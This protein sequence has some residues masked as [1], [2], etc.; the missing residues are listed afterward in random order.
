[1]F[2]I[3]RATFAW[4]LIATLGGVALGAEIAQRAF[5]RVVLLE[6]K[7]ETSAGV[8]IG[9]LN[10]DGF[11]DIVLA[12]GRHWPLHDRVLLNDGHGKFSA[13]NLGET[14]DRTYS[15]ALAD[16]NGDGSLD[17]VVSNDQPD[18]KLIYLN[19]GKARFRIAGT[20]GDPKWPTRYVALADLNGDGF[21][22]IVVANRNGGAGRP[23]ASSY[24]CFNDGKG[25]FGAG[26]PLP[27][28]SAT[29]VVC[30]DFD[31][32]G[33]IDIFVPHRDG[34]Q[35]AIFWNSGKGLF[36]NATALGPATAEIRAAAAGDLDGDGRPDIVIGDEKAKRVEVYHNI[37]HRSF[38]PAVL[39]S[40]GD[41]PYAI[42]IADLDRDGKAD[43]AIGHANAPGTILFNEGSREKFR[44][45]RWNDGQGSVYALAV[46][47]LDGDGWPDLVAARSDAPNAIWFSTSAADSAR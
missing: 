8:S 11:P 35:S 28:Q 19:D 9:D 42:A 40:S 5:E 43:V 18:R 32:D 10:G 2:A 7:G 44:P 30:A 38:A 24:L 13:A 26:Q 33:A 37:G 6:E 17:I 14:A 41:T 46:G 1:M 15:A 31:G 12:K 27:M 39:L 4:W 25:S 22:D 45:L 29:I 3:R 34:G 16:L 23:G 21:P 36:R 47:D 20:F